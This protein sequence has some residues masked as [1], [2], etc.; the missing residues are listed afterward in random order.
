MAGQVV[1]NSPE[2]SKP[3]RG[4]SE[5]PS[6]GPHLPVRMLLKPLIRINIRSRHS[7][8]VHWKDSCIVEANAGMDALDK[9]VKD[10]ADEKG[11]LS[12][13]LRHAA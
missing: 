1:N 3:C 9:A 6:I 12:L 2:P 8:T 4:S 7:C 13:S 10:V 11:L 5:R